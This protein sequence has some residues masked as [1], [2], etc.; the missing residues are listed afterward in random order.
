M[1]VVNSM[2]SGIGVAAGV[3]FILALTNGASSYLL[4]GK[5][6][7]EEIDARFGGNA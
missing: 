1:A 2:M 7:Q 5:T 3:T 6:L 4:Q